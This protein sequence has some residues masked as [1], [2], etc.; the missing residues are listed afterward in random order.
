MAR[1][2]STIPA[3]QRDGSGCARVR[4]YDASGKRVEIV[5]PGNYGSDESKQEYERILSQ[6]RVGNG[7]LP[8]TKAISDL[9]E[10]FADMV[11]VQLCSGARYGAK[12]Q[13]LHAL[14]I[15]SSSSV[16]LARPKSMTHTWPASSSIRLAGLMSRWRIP[17]RAA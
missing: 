4:T 8:A 15:R 16:I 12:V 5:L 13:T 10:I 1:L 17:C 9:A 6:L 3:C 7:A 2:R 14:W 11:P